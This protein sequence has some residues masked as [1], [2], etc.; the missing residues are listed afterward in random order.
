MAYGAEFWVPALISAAGAG[1][2]YAAQKQASNR[3][4]AAEA[5]AIMDQQKV[6][7]KAAAATNQAVQ[8]VAESD[9]N[10]IQGKATGDYISQLRRN[11]AGA[12]SG[13][14]DSALAP[15]SG[16]SARYNAGTQDAQANVNNYGNQL[17]SQ[18]AGIDAAVRQR[19][20]EGLDAN[21]LATQ[22]G[23]YGMESYGQHFVDQLRAQMAGQANPWAMLGGKLAYGLG[24]SAAD[25]YPSGGGSSATLAGARKS[26]QVAPTGGSGAMYS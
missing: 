15:V 4:D 6:Q 21:T 13:G 22:L 8:K 16:A 19:Q 23:G 7:S 20:N 2:Q 5:Q 10:A 25:W 11:A 24:Q 1:T 26:A 17:A 12:A 14:T 18:M 9:P 3:Q